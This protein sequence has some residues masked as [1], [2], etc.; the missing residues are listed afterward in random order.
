MPED[1][2]AWLVE[3]PTCPSTNTWALAHVAALAHG[4][5]VWT[6][7]QTQG[8]GQNGKPWFSPPGV[9]TA[10]F[11]VDLPP[12]AA[13]AQLSLCVGLAV[14]HVVEEL[15][16]AARVGLRWPNDCCLAGRK[17]AGI[18]CERPARGGP[19]D[20]RAAVVVGI[21]LNLDPHWDQ[22]PAALPL[23]ADPAQAPASVAEVLAPPPA[24]TVMLAALRRYL[25][26]AT[27]LLAVGGWGQLL[28]HL[29]QRDDL[30]GR[31][32][33]LDTAAGRIAGRAEGLDDEGRLRLR[34]DD[35]T[36]RTFASASVLSVGDKK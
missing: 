10:S 12:V 33:E 20:D 15:A 4:A 2:L 3:L 22:S 14:A 36:T 30:A 1:L 28:P 6:Q 26:E 23:A 13:P 17:L 31:R 8:R 5:C 24:A 18:L 21:G 11:V 35:G 7:R 16:P 32:V 9:L 29:R 25:L 34:L 19:G 27:G